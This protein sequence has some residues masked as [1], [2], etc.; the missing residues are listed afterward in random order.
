M[1][2]LVVIRD[3]ALPSDVA[4]VNALL[5]WRFRPHF[6]ASLGFAVVDYTCGS[7]AA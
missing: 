1:V 4:A 7:W 5:R 2:R 6:M 3:V